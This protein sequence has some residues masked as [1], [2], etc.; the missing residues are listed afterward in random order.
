MKIIYRQNLVAA[1]FACT[2]GRPRG[3][4]EERPAAVR[5]VPMR[6]AIG[7]VCL[8]LL[9]LAGCSGTGP[10]SIAR[11]RFDYV[12]SVSDSWKRQ[13]LLNLLKVRYSDAP[14]FMDIASVIN[15]YE[16]TG[17]VNLFGQVARLNSGDHIAGIGATGRYADKPTITYQPLAGDKFTRSLMLPIPIPS[18]LYLI[19]SGYRADLVLRI[20]VDSVNGL[21]N[22]YG[23]PGRLQIGDPQFRELMA[24]IR[25]S[26]A[27]GGMGMRMKTVTDRQSVV[28]FFRPST[29]DGIAAPVRK[30]RELLALNAS[31]KEYSVVYGTYP[32]NDTEITI[33][34]R[35]ILQI[36]IDLASHIDVPEVD[37]A[38]GRVY[39]LQRTPEQE[40]MFPPL[41]SVRSGAT[42]PGDAHV[43]V[44]YRNRWFW[45]DDRDAHSKQIFNFMMFMFSLT[46]TGS[47]QAAPI[48]T[49][50]A[51]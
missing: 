46:E 35:S 11:D 6:A 5:S 42:A 20:C 48:V 25:D 18:I 36:L 44:N 4:E 33:L 40:R 26:Q 37:L 50:P 49:V 8:S 39:G 28:M 19:Q 2:K 23:G 3:H 13:M 45:I 21:K 17:E 34:S 9:L 22:S 27:A 16:L 32:E 51:R 41:I 12:T 1:A 7:L 30:V 31:A 47:P 15:S 38:E 43:S 24:A 14:V 29:D 10:P